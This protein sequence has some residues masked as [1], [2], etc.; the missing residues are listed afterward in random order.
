MLEA[1]KSS[2]YFREDYRYYR[3]CVILYH[4]VLLLYVIAQFVSRSY[5]R[6]NI[7]LQLDGFTSF[8]HTLLDVMNLYFISVFLLGW[9]VFSVKNF[10]M[11]RDI[12]PST[13][14]VPIDDQNLSNEESGLKKIMMPAYLSIIDEVY[15][16]H[17]ILA[18][19]VLFGLYVFILTQVFSFF[20]I[21]S[22]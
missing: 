3:V 12:H 8:M 17:K 20:G 16:Y 1:V 9:F 15:L 14:T 21:V 18:F 7:N 4:T 6:Q 2:W 19:S 11:M 13:P 10:G 22:D 5:S